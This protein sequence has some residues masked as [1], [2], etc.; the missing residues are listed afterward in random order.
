MRAGINNKGVK[1]RRMIAGAAI[2]LA[3]GAAFIVVPVDS[4][5]LAIPATVGVGAFLC[6]RNKARLAGVP[7][8]IVASAL[9][10]ATVM[11]TRTTA[12]DKRPASFTSSNVTFS[13]LVRKG[14]AYELSEVDWANTQIRLPSPQP[15][16]REIVQAVNDQTPFKASVSSCGNGPSILQGTWLGK[17]SIWPKRSEP[18]VA[19]SNR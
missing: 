19:T 9:V 13:E 14:T 15:T 6:I 11:A 4:L 18:L 3:L 2:G 10:I 17:I 8:A 12:L 5:F 16:L 1:T 7:L